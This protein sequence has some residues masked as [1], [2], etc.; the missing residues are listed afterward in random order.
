MEKLA[1]KCLKGNKIYRVKYHFWVKLHDFRENFLGEVVIIWL[2]LYNKKTLIK[3]DGL[4]ELEI[5]H[6]FGY[7]S[8]AYKAISNRL[9]KKSQNNE[10]H[11]D[12]YHTKLPNLLMKL[13]HNYMYVFDKNCTT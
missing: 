9:K 7:T 4:L 11:C 5:F 10:L 8:K 2:Q 12:K 6:L 1:A 3:L 13:G